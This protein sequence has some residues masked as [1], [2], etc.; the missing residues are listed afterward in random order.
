MSFGIAGSQ[1]SQWIT[2]R[3][4]QRNTY[5]VTVFLK[6]AIY[7]SIKYEDTGFRER[8]ANYSNHHSTPLLPW[9]PFVARSGTFAV[10]QNSRRR[11]GN[12]RSADAWDSLAAETVSFRGLL[13]VYRRVEPGIFW[14]TADRA[15]MYNPSRAELIA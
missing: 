6:K 14:P 8:V 10:N 4:V 13:L 2:F 3:L 7:S 11:P 5:A 1:C 9:A 12:E 15:G